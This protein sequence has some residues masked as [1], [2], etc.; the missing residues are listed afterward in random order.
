MTTPHILLLLLV[1]AIWGFNFVVIKEGLQHFPP[2]FLCFARFLITSIP[3]I[4][5]IKRP[6]V[7]LHRLLLYSSVMFVLQFSLLF[8]AMQSGITPALAS[9][10]LQIQ[11]FF[12][13][14][15]AVLFMKET[16]HHIQMIACFVALAGISLIA[17]HLNEDITPIGLLLVL[18]AA[19]TWAL[20]SIIAKSLGEKGGLPLV[21]WSSLFAWP[22]LLLISFWIEKTD[23]IQGCIE[24]WNWQSGLSV[25]YIAYCSTLFGFGVWNHLLQKYPLSKL[26][27]FTLLAP[28]V[29]IISA[30][31]I[32]GEKL[33]WWKIGAAML[34][35][36]GLCLHL[37]GSLIFVPKRSTNLTEEP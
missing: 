8:F 14:L 16:I 10:L 13:I 5:F 31:I 1:V 20:G 12:S 35:L 22:P 34:I 30:A 25:F 7:P 26:A 3:A 28:V 18:G 32:V 21:I 15:L 37:L 23:W 29:G 36:A 2:I 11:A 24:H 9:I 33:Q 17:S 4:F 27:P 6:K 19:F